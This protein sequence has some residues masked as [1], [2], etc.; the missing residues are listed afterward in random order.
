MAAYRYGVSNRATAAIATATLI[1]FGLITPEDQNLVTD[2]NKVARAR[3]KHRNKTQ[4]KE[5]VEV[6]DV[7][8]I[9]FDGRHDKALSNIAINGKCRTQTSVEE[10]IIVID[11][12]SRHLFHTTLEPGHG[13]NIASSIYSHLQKNGLRKRILLVGCDGTNVNAG[14]KNG[15][16]V[17]LERILSREL[18]WSVCLLH[19]NELPLRH[20]F[21]YFDG[22]TSGPNSFSCPIGKSL[23]KTSLRFL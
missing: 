21:E 10:H 7:T 13:I 14:W 18:Q 15:S 9:Y 5:M 19:N 12:K 23:K 4:H 1:D 17:N 2:K 16:I 3:Q 22:K 6:I 8:G 11:Q 20:L